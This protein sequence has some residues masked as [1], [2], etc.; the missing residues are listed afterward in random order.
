MSGTVPAFV[1][2]LADELEASGHPAPTAL[3]FAIATL[4]EC[5]GGKTVAKRAV[6]DTA[7]DQITA[8]SA[9]K[10]GMPE[11]IREAVERAESTRSSLAPDERKRI[12]DRL[13][14]RLTVAEG[15]ALALP[16][17]RTPLLET[18]AKKLFG[19]DLNGDLR[20][21]LKAEVAADKFL[22]EALGPGPSAGDTLKNRS[23]GGAT[24]PADFNTQHP[25]QAHGQFGSKGGRSKRGGKGRAAAIAN[26][27]TQVQQLLATL[28]F[29]LGTPGPDGTL[30]P[31]TR[32]AL[33]AFQKRAGL[34]VTGQID[35]GTLSML[36]SD[37][38][39]LS[40]RNSKGAVNLSADQ[41]SGAA[42]VQGRGSTVGAKS[43]STRL[44][45]AA[46]TMV[47]ASFQGGVAQP[48]GGAV[49]VGMAAGGLPAGNSERF[50]GENDDPPE[51]PPNLRQAE[52]GAFERCDSCV[53]FTGKGICALYKWYVA[54][55]MVSDSYL[56]LTPTDQRHVDADLQQ[57]ADSLGEAVT[58]REK[59]ML[60][61]DSVA[62]TAAWT[63][64]K[65]LRSKLEEAADS[66]MK[67][68][69]HEP[70][71]K[72]GGPGLWKHKGLQLPAYI[73]HIANDL[74][75][76]RGMDESAAIATAIAAVKRWARGGGKVDANTRAAAAKAVAEWEALKA[77]HGGGLKEA[78]LIEALL[79]GAITFAQ[80]G[81]AAYDDAKHPRN[82][83]GQW[84]FAGGHVMLGQHQIGSVQQ[85]GSLQHAHAIDGRHLGSF[86]SRTEA[87]SAVHQAYVS[88]TRGMSSG[89]HGAEVAPPPGPPAYEVDKKAAVEPDALR[90][91]PLHE[92]ARLT[93][94]DWGSQGKGVNYAAKPYLDAMGGMESHKENYGLDSGKSII[95]Y[96]LSNAGTWK[97]PTAKAVKAELKTR[98]REA[99]EG[100]L[101][102]T[103][104][105]LD[106]AIAERI[107]AAERGDSSAF[108]VA[109]ASEQHLREA[110][111]TTAA[112]KKLA[113]SPKSQKANFAI[114]EK[115]PGSG[116]YPIQD[117]E[118]ARNALSRVAAN[119][120]PEEQARVRAAVKKKYPNIGD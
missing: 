69:V 12:T 40:S 38:A 106:E 115:A 116:S 17:G 97:G 14:H 111:L 27:I 64:E 2:R 82:R 16:N 34:P 50:G 58:A 44:R 107:A 56:T 7:R 35:N 108:T 25:R 54:G 90:A 8:F 20:E 95:A 60:D 79:E 109:F 67:A 23:G 78:E 92:I 11:A 4:R 87:G 33:M 59:A 103:F 15:L 105:K 74:R 76:E 47:E 5:A 9:A 66:M 52:E 71:G 91:A 46:E 73:Q 55:N 42:K 83:V 81:K 28:G 89:V 100:E 88:G 118:H 26:Q 85:V 65:H 94:R 18:A 63:R 84:R 120:T 13:S 72:P 77:S 45:Q 113:A 62:F 99:G 110:V 37:V 49:T 98:L 21:R 119:G 30:N 3:G 61:G 24:T 112:R 51:M 22:L 39:R 41:P 104:E 19:E 75:S 86:Q 10:K 68:T 80:I 101:V 114:P 6:R 1:A 102:D 31:S 70:V 48:Y 117:E 32:A 93:R 43:S 53:H 36:N 96:F 29:N 57:L